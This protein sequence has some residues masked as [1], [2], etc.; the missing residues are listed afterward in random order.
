MVALVLGQAERT[1]EGAQHLGRWL[2]APGL[3]ETG[4]VVNRHARELGDLF[5][6]QAGG[7]TPG[8]DREAHVG[9]LEGFA[10]AAQEVGEGWAVHRSIITRKRKPKQGSTVHG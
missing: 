4:V 6:A 3:L 7:A 9:G 5:A 8:T 2:R 10:A 1:R